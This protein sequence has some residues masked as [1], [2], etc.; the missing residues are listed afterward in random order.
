MA[1]LLDEIVQLTERYP[2]GTEWILDVPNLDLPNQLQTIDVQRQHTYGT[3]ATIELLMNPQNYLNGKSAES[4]IP[5][6]ICC[7]L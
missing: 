3:T 7:C 6:H 4:F 2:I 1:T 5:H